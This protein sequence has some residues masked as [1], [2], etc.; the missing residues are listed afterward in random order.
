MT[1]P[2]E[3]YAE[4][5]RRAARQA[6]FPELDD[7]MLDVG[8][9]LDD[10]QRAACEALD[11]RFRSAVVHFFT[12]ARA[13]ARAVASWAATPS[14]KLRAAVRSKVRETGARS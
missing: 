4:S 12:C 5:K 1:S 11:H 9:D 3:R 14:W 13:T 7:F 8:F 6:E 10:F 2:A